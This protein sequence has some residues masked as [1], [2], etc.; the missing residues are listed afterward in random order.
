MAAQYCRRLNFAIEWGYLSLM[1]FLSVIFDENIAI[2]HKLLKSRFFGLH[3]CY[4]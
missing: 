3:F 4:R 2:N 1:H